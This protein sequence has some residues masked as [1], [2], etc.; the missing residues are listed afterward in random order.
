MPLLNK[1]Q[2]VKGSSNTGQKTAKRKL[3]QLR[4]PKSKK[5]TLVNVLYRQLKSG[6]FWRQS[7]NNLM[8]ECGHTKMKIN[9]TAYLVDMHF[10]YKEL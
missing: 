9:L 6:Q 8:S 2:I 3:L 7:E 5:D 4:Y 1:R 10:Y